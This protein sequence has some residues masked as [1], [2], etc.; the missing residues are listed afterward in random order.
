MSFYNS[1]ISVLVEEIE[2]L[3]KMRILGLRGCIRNRIK[4]AEI[5]ITPNTIKLFFIP[6]NGRNINPVSIQ[7]VIE[8]IILAWKTFP[9][10]LIIRSLKDIFGRRVVSGRER[11]LNVIA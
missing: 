6:M 7:P 2:K 1:N 11:F 4:P 10:P 8:P 3:F 9:T 5:L